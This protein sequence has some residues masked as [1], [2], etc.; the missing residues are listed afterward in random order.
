MNR[1]V[2]AFF[3]DANLRQKVL[4]THFDTPE[5]ALNKLRE[6]CDVIIC[7]T[8]ELEELLEKCK[9][10]DG[11]YWSSWGAHNRL[12]A[13]VLDAVGPQ[14]KCISTCSV[15]FDFV[16]LEEVKKRKIP[17]GYTPNILNNSVAD[18]A[19]GLAIAASRRFHEGRQKIKDSAWEPRLQWMTGED[20]RDSTVGIVG[21]GGIGQT[22]AKR[23]SGF[24]V[25]HFLYCGRN[26]KPE[27]DK[28]GAKFVPFSEL[29]E[30][31]DFVFIA[32]PLTSENHKMFNA[33]VFDKMKPTSVLVNVARGDIVDQEALYD[34]LKNNKIF[35][36]GLDVMTPEPLP[37]DHPLLSLL[38]CVII[39]HL[40]GATTR[41][42]NDMATVAAINVLAGLANQPMHSP[43]Y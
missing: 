16:D 31:S 6:F 1:V 38:N 24:D 19:V 28:I 41:T 14:L 18:I 12:T 10:V 15:G 26:K 43:A 40:G 32:C 21:F 30:K 13:E 27:A 5:V 34:A 22:I 33:E 11:L 39:P 8:S 17:L 23:L 25:G 36:A 7:E 9:G 2:K 3:K 35:A 4:V 20:I 29:V 42:R 37:A